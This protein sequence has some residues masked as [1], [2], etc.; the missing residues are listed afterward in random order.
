MHS[1]K[2]SVN[3]LGFEPTFI[4]FI[5]WIKIFHLANIWTKIILKWQKIPFFIQYFQN[6]SKEFHKIKSDTHNEIRLSK[7]QPLL[8]SLLWHFHS[9]SENISSPR[10]WDEQGTLIDQLSSDEEEK[11]RTTF[12]FSYL[13]TSLIELKIMNYSRVMRNCTKGF[14]H[15]FLGNVSRVELRDK[16]DR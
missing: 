3:N 16:N 15:W 13:A 7:R 6:S 11:V 8:F 1:N 4:H 14:A 9:S 5:L 2:Q 12:E 10:H